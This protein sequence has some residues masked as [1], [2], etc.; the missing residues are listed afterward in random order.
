MRHFN[1]FIPEK[2]YLNIT[3]HK[4]QKLNECTYM[5]CTKVECNQNEI[6]G[7]KWTT[8]IFYG[9]HIKV[10]SDSTLTISKNPVY[11]NMMNS[12]DWKWYTVKEITRQKYNQ[13]KQQALSMLS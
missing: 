13:V 11:I 1:P 10:N 12:L 6:Q 5:Y 7:R 2:R 3:N 4:D 8:F 9:T